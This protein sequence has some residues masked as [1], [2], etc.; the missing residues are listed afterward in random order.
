MATL[1]QDLLSGLRSR[2]DEA[3]FGHLEAFDEPEDDSIAIRPADPAW[4]RYAVIGLP[5][6][7]HMIQRLEA[8]EERCGPRLVRS[9]EDWIIHK[10]AA[11]PVRGDVGT[12]AS[13]EELMD[14]FLTEVVTPWYGS[15]VLAF[16][17]TTTDEGFAFEVAVVEESELD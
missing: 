8:L 12:P 1:V 14:R 5:D 10:D 16:R 7:E 4:R 17:A 2:L 6:D 15:P 13:V 3:G 9:G 11:A